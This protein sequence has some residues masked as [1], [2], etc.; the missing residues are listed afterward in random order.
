MG[1]GPGTA[2][3]PSSG[4]H[5]AEVKFGAGT[6]MISSLDGG[7]VFPARSLAEG[8]LSLANCW[9]ETSV[10]NAAAGFRGREDQA[11]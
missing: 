10:H 6:A 11:E 7:G 2:S 5:K 4:P 9:P 1:Q 8:S 3:R